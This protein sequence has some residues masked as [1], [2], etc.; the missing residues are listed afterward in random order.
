MLQGARSCHLH[1]ASPESKG[2]TPSC[3]DTHTTDYC[4]K[5][6]E[7]QPNLSADLPLCPESHVLQPHADKHRMQSSDWE[8]LC[9]AVAEQ[10][11]LRPFPPRQ[12]YRAGVQ[13]IPVL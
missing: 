3:E 5:Q 13:A 1:I 2:T 4:C 9:R 7:A 11:T 8:L 6:R 12:P 10:R